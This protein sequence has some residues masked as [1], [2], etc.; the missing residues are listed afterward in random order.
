MVGRKWLTGQRLENTQIS[1]KVKLR[2]RTRGQVGRV[3]KMPPDSLNSA[4]VLT[5]TL[6]KSSALCSESG[7]ILDV[8][9][10]FANVCLC[11]QSGVQA[12]L[13]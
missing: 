7:A 3:S 4:L 9:F 13:L 6:V 5:W 2:R 1:I 12:G 8:E 10:F 11:L